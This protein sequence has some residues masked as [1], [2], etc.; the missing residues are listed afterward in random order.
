MVY[1]DLFTKMAALSSKIV[2]H[3]P[4]IYNS[5]SMIV[6]AWFVFIEAFF[7]TL[8]ALQPEKPNSPKL[9]AAN[10]VYWINISNTS[11]LAKLSN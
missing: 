7:F 6:S 9:N 5:F 8:M 11:N 3:D 10:N 1:V 4:V 2:G